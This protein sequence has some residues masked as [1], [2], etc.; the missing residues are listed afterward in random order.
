MRIRLLGLASVAMLAA[1]AP[2][3]ATDTSETMESGEAMEAAAFDTE[4]LRTG[5]DRFV[6]LWNAGD[7]AALGSQIAEDAVLMQPDGPPLEGRTAIVEAIS[8]GYDI[9]MFQQ[10][11]TADEILSLGDYAYARGTWTLN[12]TAAGEDAPVMNGKWSAVY[13]A[14]PDGAWQVWRWM[15]NQPSEQMAPAAD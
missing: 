2:Q 5:L 9:T 15:W 1:C 12:P 8:G 14:G 13:T 6:S 4:A 11:A 10:S 7:A 3:E